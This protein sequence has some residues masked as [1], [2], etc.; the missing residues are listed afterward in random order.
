MV[1]ANQERQRAIRAIEEQLAKLRGP[2]QAQARRQPSIGDEL[3]AIHNLAVKEKAAQTAKRLERLIA[4][5]QRES[6]GGRQREPQ[7]RPERLERPQRER[8]AGLRR[9]VE[10]APS[11]ER[12]SGFE[13]KSFDGQTV[14]LSDYRGKIVVLEWLNFECPYSRYHYETKATMVGLAKKYKGKNV[15][16]LA[17][18]S[19]NHTTPQPNKDFARQYKLPYPILD[20]RSGKVGHAYGAKTT[21]HMYIIN[22]RGR[23]V[24]EG[25]IDNAP[26][27]KKK[28]DMVNYV[29]KALA[30]LTGG[31]AVIIPKTK[32]YGCTVKYAR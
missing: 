8:P 7:Q 27:G 19:T 2:G 17:V 15:V 26:L 22:T 29:D 13:L 3:R 31:R 25:A 12:A 6:R 9:D 11:G 10:G 14:S 23:I 28:E 1:K 16:W 24:Y 32:P 18:N 21:P 4:R 20:D 5:Y 30:E